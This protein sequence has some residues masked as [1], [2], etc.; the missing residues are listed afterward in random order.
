MLIS[1]FDAAI[2]TLSKKFLREP[3]TD[4]F[5]GY[6]SK[7]NDIAAMSLVAL[8]QHLVQVTYPVYIAYMEMGNSRIWFAESLS[9]Y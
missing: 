8:Q 9:K 3:G 1:Y 2:L 6:H 4:R 7:T 5:M